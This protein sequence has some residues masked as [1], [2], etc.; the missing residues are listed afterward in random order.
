MLNLQQ[1]VR[2][3]LLV[4]R[5]TH[6]S[7]RRRRLVHLILAINYSILVTSLRDHSDVSTE[8]DRSSRPRRR[9]GLKTG[10]SSA[11]RPRLTRARWPNHRPNVARS[12]KARTAAGNV[13]II[14]F[15]ISDSHPMTCIP[16]VSFI[17][18]LIQAAGG[19]SNATS[20]PT[21]TPR[22]KRKPADRVAS[23]A[24]PVSRRSSSACQQPLELL[25]LLPLRQLP[26]ES[27]G[28]HSA[29]SAWR[30]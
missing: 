16:W 17:A 25:L 6:S 27:N 3:G 4:R 1:F 8:L 20:T 12:A 28:C 5:L 18:E 24:R 7:T 14:P 19:R 22:P 26:L 29:W 9:Q 30:R 10:S 2:H 21:A 13:S 15:F 11:L 23:V